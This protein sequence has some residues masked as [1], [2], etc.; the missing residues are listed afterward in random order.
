[1]IKTWAVAV[2]HQAVTDL[3]LSDNRGF[4]YT[5]NAAV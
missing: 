5:M 2:W 3:K 1:M 4:Y